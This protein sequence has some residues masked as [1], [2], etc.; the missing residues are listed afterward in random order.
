MQPLS[1]YTFSLILFAVFLNATAQLLLKAGMNKIG[2]FAF[3]WANIVPVSLQIAT[4][5][6]ILSGLFCYVF[7][8]AVWLLVLSRTEVGIAYPLVSLAY[9]ITAIAAYYLFGEQLS[10]IRILGIGVIMLG[11]YM[12]ART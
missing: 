11:V 5:P 3:S 8:V 9:I 2:E 4:N 12:V 7:A 1:L 6:F 10:L